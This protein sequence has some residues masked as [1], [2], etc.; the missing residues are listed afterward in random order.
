MTS[1]TILAQS[2]A[3]SIAP[4]FF[5]G[6][7]GVCFF[8]MISALIAEWWSRKKAAP[9]SPSDEESSVADEDAQNTKEEQ[10]QARREAKEQKK[11][12][13]ARKKEEKAAAKAEA[14][15]AKQAKKKKK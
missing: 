15:A 8:L 3:T 5:L 11:L 4:Y 6:I 9:E 14:N 1:S 2:D 12:E 13:K 10:K 7:I